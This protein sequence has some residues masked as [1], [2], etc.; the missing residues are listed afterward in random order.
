VNKLPKITLLLLLV[1]MLALFSC[2]N[3]PRD[4]RPGQKLFIV[5]TT[6]MLG[7][8]V[9]N[10]AGDSVVVE[11]LMGPG[12]DP[13]LYKATQGDIRKLTQADLV[14]YNGLFLEGKMEEIFERLGKTK[15]VL[16]AA[17]GIDKAK[18]RDN[19]IYQNEYDPHV[20]FD[21]QLWKEVVTN[22]SLKLQKMDS[23]NAQ[24]YQDNTK[25]FS[26]KLDVLH[27]SVAEQIS[28]IPAD[29]RVLITAH[30]AF[31]YFGD[32]YQIE[33]KGLQGISTQSEFGLK[34]ITDLVKFISDRQVKAVFV[35]TSVSERAIRAVVEGCNEKGF[36]VIIGGY[37]YSDAMG[38][39]DSEEGTYIGMVMANVNTI[40]NAL[41]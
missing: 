32:A 13:H 35:E 12:V 36:P 9:I 31:G 28:K 29:Q 23:A 6:G 10:I 40:V 18:L 3:N 15:P 20:W 26:N 4:I 5:T 16:A 30:D 11:A 1:G 37:L 24:F 2:Q 17:A 25:I 41:K 14:I 19:A 7:D 33:V 8:A 22:V 34:D 38:A 27:F 39:K 21:V